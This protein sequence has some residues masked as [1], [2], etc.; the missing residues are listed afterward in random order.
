M[1]SITL[2]SQKLLMS[3]KIEQQILPR[4]T[5]LNIFNYTKIFFLDFITMKMLRITSKILVKI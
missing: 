3:I 2:I 4:D 5:I 1:A